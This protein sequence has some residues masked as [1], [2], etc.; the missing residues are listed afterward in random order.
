MQQELDIASFHIRFYTDSS[1]ANSADQSSQLGYI[2]TLCDKFNRC[3]ILSCRSYNSRR[4]V[5]SV[6]GAEVYAFA[7]G[8]DVAHMLRF[9]LESI[10]NRKLRLCILT[11]IKSLF[12]TTV[13]NS[14]ISEK[15]LMIEVQ[16]AREAYQQLEILDIGHI[17]GSNNPAD[18]LTK[19][20]TCLALV[21][22]L[23]TGIMDHHINQWVI[24]NNKSVFTSPSSLP[25]R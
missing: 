2:A 22:L 8:F 1:I 23:T 9:D 24:R 10:M 4:V 19:P 15:R 18:G 6:M 14:F 5:R 11:D 17:S 12:D 16:A 3:N 21:K 13:K 25:C 7:D 20:K